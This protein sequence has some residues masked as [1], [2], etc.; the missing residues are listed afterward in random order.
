M[1]PPSGLVACFGGDRRLLPRSAADHSDRVFGFLLAAAE[2]IRRWSDSLA[3]HQTDPHVPT[4]L[5]PGCPSQFNLRSLTHN[6]SALECG[7]DTL[8]KQLVHRL[9]LLPLLRDV[10]PR[11]SEK[12]VRGAAC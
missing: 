3:A 12:T 6:S 2:L 4:D 8:R 11:Y 5:R 1:R 10:E 9:L 7:L